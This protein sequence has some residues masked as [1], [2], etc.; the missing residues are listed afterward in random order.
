MIELSRNAERALEAA[1]PRLRGVSHAVAALVSAPLAVRAILSAPSGTPRLA[2]AL[3]TLAAVLM[4]SLSAGM[5]WRERGPTATEL[6]IR[7]DHTGIYVMIASATVA[8]AL[9]GLPVV[10]QRWVIPTAVVAAVV[11]L[12][13]EWL[14]RATPRGFAHGMF[15]GAGW[16]MMVGIVQLWTGPGGPVA[17]W[18]LL[19][20]GLA[21]TAGAVIVALRRPDPWPSWFGYHELW[22]A[23]VIVAVAC[24]WHLVV[25]ILAG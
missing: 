21:Y 7:L 14:P 5:H 22:H 2:V 19:A 10:W 13:V 25:G 11:G 4:L 8:V 17:V 9:L 18:W 1:T 23:L 6:W 16:V 20:G 15:L 3:Y 24:H 12:V